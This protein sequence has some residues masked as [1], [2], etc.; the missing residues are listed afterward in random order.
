MNLESIARSTKRPVSLNDFLE[1]FES[2]VN[3]KR[4]LD[5][6]LTQ[7]LGEIENLKAQLGSRSDSLLETKERLLRQEF[8]R[9]YQDLLVE[10]RKERTLHGKQIKDLKEQ[11]S[12]CICNREKP[13]DPFWNSIRHRSQQAQT[14]GRPTTSGIRRT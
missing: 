14:D 13:T 3:Q 10:V 4:E 1:E 12:G 11:L 6:Q 5:A 8:E 2:M 9:K 7:A